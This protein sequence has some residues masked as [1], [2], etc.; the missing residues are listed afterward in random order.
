MSGFQNDGGFP[1]SAAW[2]L[3]AEGVRNAYREK[4]KREADGDGGDDDGKRK[5]K[6]KATNR[7]EEAEARKAKASLTIKPGESLKHFNR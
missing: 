1:K 4:R 6:R 5:R 3:N 7:Q 2:V